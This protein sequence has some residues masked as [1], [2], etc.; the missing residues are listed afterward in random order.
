MKSVI[1]KP[2]SD[3]TSQPTACDNMLQ[4]SNAEEASASTEIQSTSIP[5]ATNDKAQGSPK[6]FTDLDYFDGPTVIA[7]VCPFFHTRVSC[8]LGRGSRPN[9][10][11]QRT[12]VR[13]LE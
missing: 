10:M 2:E 11:R 5:T 3:M 13:R 9:H 1:T 8:S 12:T 4:D 6:A 7:E